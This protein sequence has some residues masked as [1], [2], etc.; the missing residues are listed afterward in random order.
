MKSPS[1]LSPRLV[2]A[3]RSLL[4]AALLYGFLVGVKALEGGI[5]AFGADFAENLF[6]NVTH[7][8]AGLFAGILATVLVQSSSVSTSTIVGLVGAGALPLASA[9]PMVM[10]ANIGTTVTNTLVSL[11]HV[12]QGPEFRRA[13]AGATV[14]DFFNLLTVAIA[15]PLE[16]T[17][18]FLSR[19]AEAITELVG[20]GENL[21][22]VTVESPIKAAVSWPVDLVESALEGTAPALHGTLLLVMGL[23]LIFAALS[24]IT[25]TMR[26][27]M[28]GRIERS[29][30]RMLDK[31]AGLGA[32]LL[33]VVVTI[34]VQ[35]SS[36]TTSILIPMLAAGI[37]TLGNAYPVTLG[38]N[39]GT[40]ITA[41]LASVA[42]VA[43]EA[44]TIAI[45]H[46][47]FNLFGILVFY[48]VPLLRRIPMR[49]AQATADVAQRNR[50]WVVGYV[51]GLFVAVPLIGLLALA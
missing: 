20:R 6:D 17:T 22:A 35:S 23:A 48:P 46:T 3:A 33:G 7:P 13:F 43:P 18:G 40:T 41:L 29:M 21:S 31:G 50:T 45:V 19:S 15:L 14:H 12:R 51:G 24:L 25:K 34:L 5:N 4:V 44:L 27:L 28:A 30:N 1:P 2:T 32:M 16:L 8:L 9:V 49:L 10:G 36:I 42:A 11:G 37:L 39:L 26:A 47:L 38:A